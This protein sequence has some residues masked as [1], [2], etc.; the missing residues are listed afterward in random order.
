MRGQPRDARAMRGRFAWILLGA[1]CV[2]AASDPPAAPDAAS[3]PPPPRWLAHVAIAGVLTNAGARLFTGGAAVPGASV[4]V[5]N[6]VTVSVDIAYALAPSLSVTLYGG[7]P[8]RSVATATG[9]AAPLHN[10]VAVYSGPPMLTL[11]YHFLRLGPFS[12]ALGFGVA[13]LTSFDLRQSA[14]CRCALA[15]AWGAAVSLGVD[16]ELDGLRTIHAYLRQARVSTTLGGHYAGIA[17]KADLDL[18][19]TILG[20]GYGFRF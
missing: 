3:A 5:G 8:T 15:D 1:I 17:G 12:P 10:L 16:Y 14:L 19:P 9:S 13:R 6:A 4:S 11:D 7:L 20:I 18:T 2:G